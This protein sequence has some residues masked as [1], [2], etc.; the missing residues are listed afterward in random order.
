MR[1]EKWTS[2]CVGENSLKKI[3]Q[4]WYETELGSVIVVGKRKQQIA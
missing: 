3:F 1:P 2:K 4:A